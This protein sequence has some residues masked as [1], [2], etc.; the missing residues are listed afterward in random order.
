M[1]L[2]HKFIFYFVVI[3]S[4]LSNAMPVYACGVPYTSDGRPLVPGCMRLDVIVHNQTE[5]TFVVDGQYTPVASSGSPVGQNKHFAEILPDS[6]HDGKPTILYIDGGN[7]GSDPDKVDTSV[8]Y[9]AEKEGVRKGPTMTLHLKK[10]A[11]NSKSADIHWSDDHCYKN[12]KA[13][14]A[15]DFWKTCH[16]CTFMADRCTWG[17][18]WSCEWVFDPNNQFDIGH[19]VCGY[20][21]GPD[22]VCM[23]NYIYGSIIPNNAVPTTSNSAS[24]SVRVDPGLYTVGASL[25][26]VTGENQG[27]DRTV[28]YTNFARFILSQSSECGM[29]NKCSLGG[30]SNDNKEAKLEFYIKPS[31]IETLT[32]TFPFNAQTPVAKIIKE[33]IYNHL[34]SKYVGQLGSYFSYSPVEVGDKTLAFSTL[35]NAANCP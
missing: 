20:H 22:G 12:T 35:C 27:E 1:T 3:G 2:T 21:A 8:R 7:S 24:S 11:C 19:P 32:I 6:S 4:S 14:C 17:A 9:Y 28:P 5:Y 10:A 15:P 13:P 30:S 31:L 26:A 34:N 23:D 16:Y 25:N 18:C 29:D 33:S